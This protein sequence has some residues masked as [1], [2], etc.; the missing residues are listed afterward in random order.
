MGK[1]GIGVGFE[2]RKIVN[3]FLMET[4]CLVVFFSWG[5]FEENLDRK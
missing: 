4:G 2:G 5:N 3:N 1:C